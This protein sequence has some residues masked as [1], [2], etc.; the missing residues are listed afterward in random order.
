MANN[1]G[2]GIRV[3]RTGDATWT[4]Y[5]NGTSMGAFASRTLADSLAVGLTS[6]AAVTERFGNRKTAVGEVQVVTLSA[7]DGTDSF[8]LRLGE[9]ETVPFVR[10]TNA[11][12]A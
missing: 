3:H 5:K 11:T 8:A 7:F 2:N 4:V 1:F 9:N 6:N 12:A 10:Q